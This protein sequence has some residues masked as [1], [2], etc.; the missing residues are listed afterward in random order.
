[1]QESGG[2]RL[3][4]G[5]RLVLVSAGVSG[6]RAETLARRAMRERADQGLDVVAGDRISEDYSVGGDLELADLGV[7]G[8]CA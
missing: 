2:G 7:V 1:M 6:T 3:H 4:A 8:T 5:G